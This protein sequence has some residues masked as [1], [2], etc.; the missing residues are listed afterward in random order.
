VI[1]V[2]YKAISHVEWRHSRVGY[3]RCLI[4]NASLRKISIFC[5]I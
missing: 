3:I 2:D 1:G 4:H 5:K